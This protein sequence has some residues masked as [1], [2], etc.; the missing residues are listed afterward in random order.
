MKKKAEVVGIPM[1]VV[2]CTEVVVGARCMEEEAGVSL[3]VGAVRTLVAAV[4]LVGVMG[5]LVAVVGRSKRAEVESL[6]V[7][8]GN[9][10]VAAVATNRQVGE[11][12]CVG[13]VEVAEER[14]L[15]EVVSLAAE[16]VVTGR[17]I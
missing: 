7:E 8:A 16:V 9:S 13:S 10:A 15:V 1:V 17:S 2:L 11:E 14:I 6:A 3:V 5:V 12:D 4:S